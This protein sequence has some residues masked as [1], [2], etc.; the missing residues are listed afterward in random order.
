MGFQK[1][2]RTRNEAINIKRTSGITLPSRINGDGGSI[3]ILQGSDKKSNWPATGK[4][5]LAG[6][7]NGSGN[8]TMGGFALKSSAR[9]KPDWFVGA[10]IMEKPEFKFRTNYTSVAFKRQNKPTRVNQ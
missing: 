3:S 7:T 2:I 8:K 4:F 5:G 10:E 9:S 6:L 1:K